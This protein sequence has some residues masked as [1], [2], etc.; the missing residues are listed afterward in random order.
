MN[1]VFIGGS[2]AQFVKSG[3]MNFD[4]FENIAR[5]QFVEIKKANFDYPFCLEDC[6]FVF[7]TFFNAYKKYTGQIHPPLKAEQIRKIMVHM[8]YCF[9]SYDRFIDFEP[10][11]YS[12][13]IEAYFRTNY[14]NCNYRIN[15]F[16]SGQI[17][18]IKF[19]EAVY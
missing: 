12:P 10:E 5:T 3:K 7:K 16:F 9:S 13:M 8:P 1:C 17:R 14:R 15:H 19:Y 6:L 18:E 11:D 2:G 4:L